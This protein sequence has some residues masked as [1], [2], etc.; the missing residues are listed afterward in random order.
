MCVGAS[1]SSACRCCQVRS[2]S[3]SAAKSM[4]LEVGQR[5]GAGSRAARAT[6][7]AA[8]AAPHP[9]H[10]ATTAG[11]TR[12]RNARRSRRR[13]K[14]SL[15]GIESSPARCS[16]SLNACATSAG[17]GS[18]SNP[19]PSTIAPS[20]RTRRAS[21]RA[22]S[23]FH[24]TCFLDHDLRPEMLLDLLPRHRCRQEDAALGSAIV[25]IRRH[26]ELRTRQRVRKRQHGS[27]PVPEQEA[28]GIAAPLRDA[29]GVGECQQETRRQRCSTARRAPPSCRRSARAWVRIRSTDSRATRAPPTNGG[30][31]RCASRSSRMRMSGSAGPPS[32]RRTSR[33]STRAAMSAA[34]DV[35]SRC[36]RADDHVT[37]P[38]VQAQSCEFFTVGGDPPGLVDRGESLEQLPRL[39]QVR[40]RV[41]HRASAST[42]RPSRWLPA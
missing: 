40:R 4:R 2:A 28:R 10:R 16:P 7:R 22:A 12:C 6:P 32:L 11:S 3:C 29:I 5:R 27:S 33:S 35:A 14:P 24:V 36:A 23:A 9:T 31:F 13:M 15:H 41:A 42:S 26:D 20:R 34:S 19:S 25:E 38:G 21:T 18:R 30:V 1:A 17:S 39:G 37:E 8:R